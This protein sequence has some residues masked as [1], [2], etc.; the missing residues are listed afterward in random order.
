MH[1]RKIIIVLF[2]VLICSLDLLIQKKSI[3]A[4]PKQP[5]SLLLIS[6]DT[7]RAD[8]MSIY[9]YNKKTTPNIDLWAKDAVVFNNFYTVIP[10]TFPSFAALMTGLNPVNTRILNNV[11]GTTDRISSNTKTLAKILKDNSYLT[12]AFY[13]NFVLL[14]K[15]SGLKNGFDVYDYNKSWKSTDPDYQKLLSDSLNW[16]NE[17]KK[18]PFFLWIHLSDPHAPYTPPEEFSCLFNTK[19]C[20]VIKTTGISAL[21]KKM[22]DILGCR[23]NSDDDIELYKTL[24]DGEVRQTDLVVGKIL[25]SLHNMNL[26][27]NTV[28]ILYGDHGESFDH[29]YDFLHREVLYNSSVKIPLIIR[30]P[31]A[32]TKETKINRL[33]DNT[34]ILPTILNLLNIPSNNLTFDGTSFSDIFQNNIFLK[35]FKSGE[36]KYVYSM[37]PYL[38]KFS[39][40]DGQYKY[41][42]SLEGTCLYNNQK[43]ELY[44]LKKDP[45]ETVNLYNPKKEIGRDFKTNLLNYLSKY[46]L[47]QYTIRKQNNVDIDPERDPDI[48]SKLKSLGY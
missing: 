34:D 3:F 21:E 1:N 23:V 26:D 15:Y 24:Y 42:Y 16:L 10:Y 22:K 37:N 36:K 31:D 48:L 39:I 32:I 27:K 19:Y 2:L 41:I 47:P 46:N 9:G 44:D 40:T 25:D 5:K 20:D 33:I 8:H 35:I 29:N 17:N 13:T 14:N 7:L 4:K 28:V 11:I 38:N 45:Q 6:V 12:A 30:D 18:G 43:E